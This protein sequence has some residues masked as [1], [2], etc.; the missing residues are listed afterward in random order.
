MSLV[1]STSGSITTL[2]KPRLHVG[3]TIGGTILA[4]GSRPGHYAVRPHLSY[5]ARVLQKAQCD[6]TLFSPFTEAQQDSQLRKMRASFPHHHRV[7]SRCDDLSD[8]SGIMTA[9]CESAGCDP[10]RILMIDSSI[11]SK[12]WCHQ[13]LLMEKFTPQKRLR[14]D[15]RAIASAIADQKQIASAADDMALVAVADMVLELS[16][17]LGSSVSDYLK[18]EP[19]IEKVRVPG[20]GEAYFLPNEN[21]DHIEMVKVL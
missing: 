20:Y 8:F 11:T 1:S 16:K 2:A 18:V 12:F 15:H 9:V 5:F 6:V 19:L 4:F 10:R 14:G 21:C 17:A 3:L 7:I 13:T